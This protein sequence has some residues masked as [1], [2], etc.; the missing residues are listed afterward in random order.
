MRIGIDVSQMCYSGT[1]VARYVYGLTH[2]LLSANT[3]HE[4]VLFAGTLRQRSY[5]TALMTQKPWDRAT[6]KILPLPP[7][8]VGLALNSHS[9]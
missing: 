1:G 3:D 7:K 9:R 6:W 8:L 5:F 4:F 2:T